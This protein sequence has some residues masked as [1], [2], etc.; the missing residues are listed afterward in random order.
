LQLREAGRFVGDL[1]KAIALRARLFEEGA[2]FDPVD[3]AN[4]HF[5]TQGLAVEGRGVDM[6][7]PR[8]EQLVDVFDGD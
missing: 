6:V 1:L 2:E 3:I 4:L 7:V 5:L 8:E